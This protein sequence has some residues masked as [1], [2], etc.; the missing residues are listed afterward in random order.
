M[1]LAVGLGFWV[2]VLP[3]IAGLVVPGGSKL[4][5]CGFRWICVG[6]G[7]SIMIWVLPLM[8]AKIIIII[9]IIII[10]TK[11][12]VEK[13][14]PNKLLLLKTDILLFLSVIF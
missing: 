3:V 4:M 1:G 10:I 8:I 6:C 11:E 5:G 7:P 9:I 13:H 2:M 12:T 14:F